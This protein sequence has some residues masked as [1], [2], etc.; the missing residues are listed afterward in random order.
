MRYLIIFVIFL[1]GC[2]VTSSPPRQVQRFNDTQ[3]ANYQPTRMKFTAHKNGASSFEMGVWAGLP[4][5]TAANERYKNEIFKKFIDQCG[6]EKSALKEVRV[7]KHEPP[8]WYEVWV[9]NS[10]S[11]KRYDKSIGMSVVMK[12]D[13]TTNITSVSFYGECE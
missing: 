11:S 7:V 10:Q 9:F 3:E 1:A 13:D 12:F 5:E 6:L 8:I 4:G 2:S